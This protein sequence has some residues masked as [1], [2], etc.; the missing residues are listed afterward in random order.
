MT[1]HLSKLVLLL[2]LSI[3]PPALAARAGGAQF[4]DHV[5]VARKTLSLNGVAVRTAT[6]F[7]V[8]VYA[9]G[10]YLERRSSDAGQILQSSAPKR[11]A[12]KFLRDVDRDQIENAWIDGLRKNAKDARPFEPRMRLLIAHIPDLK[13]GDQLAFDFVRGGVQVTC[14]R[15]ARTT[16][17]GDDFARALLA[18]MLGLKPADEDL[19]DGLLGIAN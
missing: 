5:E 4:P 1:Q 6:I 16:I 15:G 8:K 17:A 2:A 10:L 19:K 3:A 18:L 12:L 9:A 11:L 13:K 7:N 14:A